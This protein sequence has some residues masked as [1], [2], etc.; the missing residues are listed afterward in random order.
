[1]FFFLAWFS[2]ESPRLLFVYLPYTEVFCWAFLPFL[3]NEKSIAFE[4]LS[5]QIIFMLSSIGMVHKTCFVNCYYYSFAFVLP[6]NCRVNI[7][8]DIFSWM[9]TLMILLPTETRW[10]SSG[11][12]MDSFKGRKAR[13]G[14]WSM[15]VCWT[16]MQISQVGVYVPHCF[17]SFALS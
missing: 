3:Y 13:R 4:V 17:S 12:C 1:M 11:R 9:C 7:F 2:F 5:L 16:S 14:W 15:P 6:A 10:I 8:R